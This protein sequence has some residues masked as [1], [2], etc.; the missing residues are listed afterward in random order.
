MLGNELNKLWTTS[1]V[2]ELSEDCPADKKPGMSL[3][4]RF[5]ILVESTFLTFANFYPRPRKFS[6]YWRTHIRDLL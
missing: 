2:G 5:D 4:G 3:R 6:I 1:T